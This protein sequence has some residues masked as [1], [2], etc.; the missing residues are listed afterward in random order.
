MVMNYSDILIVRFLKENRDQCHD[1]FSAVCGALK[2]GFV[3]LERFCVFIYTSDCFKWQLTLFLSLYVFLCLDA[4]MLCLLT[5]VHDSCIVHDC[6][7]EIKSG[8]KG[9]RRGEGDSFPGSPAS[10]AS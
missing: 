8:R 10:P 4:Y 7:L 1:R 3:W 5:S 2:I 9:D 6:M